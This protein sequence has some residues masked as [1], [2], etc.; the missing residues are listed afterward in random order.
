MTLDIPDVKKKKSSRK[1]KGE[2]NEGGGVYVRMS[3]MTNA[4][5]R[6]VAQTAGRKP[7][8]LLEMLAEQFLEL[9]KDKQ[10]SFA[11]KGHGNGF[12]IL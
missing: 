9:P 1:A 2:G 12:P 8:E 11:A 6:E 4:G 10:A 5:I 3:E 7:G